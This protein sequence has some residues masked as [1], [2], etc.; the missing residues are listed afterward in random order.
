MA[1]M[2]EQLRQIM[3]EELEAVAASQPWM[4]ME[5]CLSLLDGVYQEYIMTKTFGQSIA[6]APPSIEP[7]QALSFSEMLERYQVPLRQ[8]WRNAFR[9]WDG[10]R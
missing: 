4:S 7:E 2:P 6:E 8:V 3:V 9:R 1:Q 10:S 5:L